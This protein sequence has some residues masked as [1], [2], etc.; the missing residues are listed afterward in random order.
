MQLKEFNFCGF[1]IM[2][3]FGDSEMARIVSKEKGI[4]EVASCCQYVQAL[5]RGIYLFMSHHTTKGNGTR[6]RISETFS[7]IKPRKKKYKY[8]GW[9]KG[10]ISFQSSLSCVKLD[11]RLPYGEAPSPITMRLA[12]KGGLGIF[13]SYIYIILYLF[14]VPFTCLSLLML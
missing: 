11:F 14:E 12:E 8:K 4:C 2:I 10:K 5:G 1:M 6:T 13:E 9:Y 7:E 3:P